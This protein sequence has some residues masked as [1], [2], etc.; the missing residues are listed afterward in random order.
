LRQAIAAGSAAV[1]QAA[2]DGDAPLEV[3]NT[4]ES[5]ISEIA[6][7]S[8][9]KGYSRVGEILAESFGSIDNLYRTSREITGLATHHT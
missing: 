7:K 9:K 8:A 4:L 3:I 5:R 2:D 1:Y 6:G